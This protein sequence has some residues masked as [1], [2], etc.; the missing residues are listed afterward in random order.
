MCSKG[1]VTEYSENCFICG[2]ISEVEHHLV[3][4]TACRELSELDRLKAP[5][6]N[7]CH[8][9]GEHLKRIHG[10]PIT[11][12]LSKIIG[13]L[14][15]EKEYA[16]NKAANFAMIIDGDKQERDLKQL[17]NRGSREAFRKRYG[18]SYL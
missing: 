6:C 3:F 8:N 14:V 10:N 9:T 12:K 1:I 16:V 2:R 5:I 17:I 18:R 7:N 4:G 11:E 13:Q 15:W